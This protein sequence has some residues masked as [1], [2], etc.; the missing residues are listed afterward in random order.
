MNGMKKTN[1]KRRRQKAESHNRTALES[2]EKATKLYQGVAVVNKFEDEAYNRVGYTIVSKFTP[3]A[4]D[5]SGAFRKAVVAVVKAAFDSIDLELHCGTHPRLRVVDHISFHPRAQTSLGET[6]RLAKL[7]ATDIGSSLQVPTSLY[8]AAHQEGKKLDLIRRQLGYFNPNSEGNQWEGALGSDCLPLKPDEGPY[9]AT[10]T[11]GVVVVG[12]TQW[13]DNYNVPIFTNKITAV[14]RI[15]RRV[16]GRG[17]GI[18]SVQAMALAHGEDIIEVA[19]N[20]LEPSKFIA[21]QV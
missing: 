11:E 17:G 3:N 5:G 6:A 7:V 13:V 19:C 18:P 20:L 8:G 1:S 10:P 2:I 21:D 12:A 4:V 9:Q 16:S 15:S 14:R